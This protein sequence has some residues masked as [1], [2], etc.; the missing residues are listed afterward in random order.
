[1]A[2]KQQTEASFKAFCETTS[3]TYTEKDARFFA[4]RNSGYTGPIDQDG[5]AVDSLVPPAT[6]TYR[7]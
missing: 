3:G 7:G 5:N 4:L 6:R 1:M 2:R